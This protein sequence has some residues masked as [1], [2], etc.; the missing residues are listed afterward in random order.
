MASC[1]RALYKKAKEPALVEACPVL[2]RGLSHLA[3]NGLLTCLSN[4]IIHQTS[5]TVGGGDPFHLRDAAAG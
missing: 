1:S 4:G 3:R 2:D 5:R